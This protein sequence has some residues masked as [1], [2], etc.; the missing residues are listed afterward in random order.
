MDAEEVRVCPRC[1]AQV[2]ADMNQCFECL[3]MFDEEEG[4]GTE[5][6]PLEAY[7]E[8]FEDGETEVVAPEGW[9]LHM[10]TASVDA[11]M[12]VPQTGLMVGRGESCDVVL[13]AKS[14]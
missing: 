10:S 3:C 6:V 5:E 7:P 9:V 13:H 12:P 4:W 2:F 14:V 8:Q 11:V 1:G